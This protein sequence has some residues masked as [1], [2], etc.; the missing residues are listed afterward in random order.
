MNVGFFRGAEIADPKGCGRHG[1]VHA[2][3][4]AEARRRL[5]RR[6][7][8]EAHR[9]GLPRHEEA[10]AGGVAAG[11]LP[12]AYKCRRGLANV[13]SG[14]CRRDFPGAGAE[15]SSA[16]SLRALGDG[17]CPVIDTPRLLLREA[18][19]DD[20]AFMLELMNEPSYVDHIGDRGIR[21]VADAVRYIEEK[22]YGELRAP[23][24]WAPHRG[25]GRK[26]P[27]RSGSAGL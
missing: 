20:A 24:V 9:C 21:A 12:R 4:E 17:M 8:K 23:R 5:R 19:S 1:K 10:G 26:G 2:S 16:G 7:P 14:A 11:E 27:V 15:P 25:V 22:Y 3:R 13:R 18:G 6:G